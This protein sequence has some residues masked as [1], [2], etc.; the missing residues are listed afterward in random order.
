MECSHDI[1]ITV[2][3]DLNLSSEGDFAAT[4][5]GE[6]DGI[7]FLDK[8]GAERSVLKGLAGSNGDNSAVVELLFGSW[9]E[10]NSSLSHGLGFGL[11]DNNSVEERSKRLERE[12]LQLIYKLL[13]ASNTP[14]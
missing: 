13:K 12:H 5:F 14:S 4:I 7:A 3:E 2:D 11:S 6:E 1:V 9:R 10:D 8:G